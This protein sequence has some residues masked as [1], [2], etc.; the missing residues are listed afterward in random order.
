MEKTLHHQDALFI[1]RRRLADVSVRKP[2]ALR[3]TR[4][5]LRPPEFN[6]AARAAGRRFFSPSC[7][8]VAKSSPRPRRR[9]PILNQG[10]GGGAQV[11]TRDC[12]VWGVRV[13][14]AVVQSFFH[15]PLR[16]CQM[17]RLPLLCKQLRLVHA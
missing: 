11:K 8:R 13:G 17:S 2:A 14:H 7:L 10:G 5:P 12:A 3:I 4:P 15:Q 1:S 16:S 6:V 9:R